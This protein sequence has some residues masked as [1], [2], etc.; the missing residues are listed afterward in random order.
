M[1]SLRTANVLNE[2]DSN[3]ERPETSTGGFASSAKA[4]GTRGAKTRPT[5]S[6]G[7]NLHSMRLW[8]YDVLV[9]LV[10]G[11]LGAVLAQIGAIAPAILVIIGL[12]ELRSSALLDVRFFLFS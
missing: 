12:K 10:R 9:S 2:T 3:I 7:S 4:A 5:R 6:L 11:R 1:K 8:F